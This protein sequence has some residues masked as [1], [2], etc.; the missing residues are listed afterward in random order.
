[1][2]PEAVLLAESRPVYLSSTP[3]A[4]SRMG[5]LRTLLPL[6]CP[7]TGGGGGLSCPSGRM[8][9]SV[10]PAGDTDTRLLPPALS[11]ELTEEPDQR[12]DS[13]EELPTDSDGDRRPELP[14]TYIETAPGGEAGGLL[15]SPGWAGLSEVR[16]RCG[17]RRPP[18]ETGVRGGTAERDPTPA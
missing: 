15:H 4:S 7:C 17:G 2:S 13:R 6:C 8:V 3:V 5:T 12:R 18:L 14:E 16:L 9:T 10:A 1:M 11:R